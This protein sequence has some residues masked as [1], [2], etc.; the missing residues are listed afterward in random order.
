MH[1]TSIYTLTEKR[2]SLARRVLVLSPD[3]VDVVA[4]VLPFKAFF[5]F[6]GTAVGWILV[7]WCLM[8][9]AWKPFP[10]FQREIVLAEMGLEVGAGWCGAVHA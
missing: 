9:E 5:P 3:E 7:G 1:K 6:V 2:S 8:T 10:V 4:L